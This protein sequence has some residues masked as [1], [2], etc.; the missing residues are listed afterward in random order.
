MG[1]EI[2]NVALKSDGTVWCWGWNAFGQL[3][4]GTTN[5]S[6]VPTQTGLTAT[7]PLTNVVKLGGRPYFTLAE[8]ADG[9]IWAWGMNQFGQMGNGTVHAV[10]Q[11]PQVTVPVMVSNSL[12][13]GPI[14]GA[15]QITCGYQFGAALATNGTVWTWGS[16][17]HGEQG[18]GTRTTNY[19]PVQVPGL[20][21]ITQISAGWFHI[22]A[23]N[24]TARFGRGE[25]IPTARS[26][27]APTNNRSNAGAGVEREQYRGGFRRR[28]PFLR[29]RRRRHV[30][31]WGLNDVGE[32]GNRRQQ[33]R[34]PTPFRRKFSRTNS[35]TA[36]AML[37]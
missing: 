4:N 3:G 30:W 25:I 27:T 12:P 34:P 16:G 19:I 7:P 24:P 31:K 18:T 20:T 22:L 1:G 26:A 21:N 35:A 37:S 14:N 36:S 13:G 29:A 33:R 10:W 11:S 9:T 5:D 23:R 2:H 6:W 28:Q 17:T 8:K 32:L 15:L